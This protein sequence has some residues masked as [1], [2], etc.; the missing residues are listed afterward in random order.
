MVSGMGIRESKMPKP[1]T[2]AS[3]VIYFDRVPVC[4][5]KEVKRRNLAGVW[6]ATSRQFRP[7]ANL[8]SGAGSEVSWSS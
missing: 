6:I 8:R 5:V 2:F 4:F 3:M 7:Q 1:R